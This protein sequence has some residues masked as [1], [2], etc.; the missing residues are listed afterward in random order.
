MS[1]RG[2]VSARREEAGATHRQRQSV[3]R[4]SHEHGHPAGRELQD[5]AQEPKAEALRHREE[6]LGDGVLQCCQQVCPRRPQDQG[7]PHSSPERS[8]H[9]PEVL[10]HTA[11]VTTMCY[12]QYAHVTLTSLHINNKAPQCSYWLEL[13]KIFYL[14]NNV[15]LNQGGLNFCLSIS[16]FSS[17]C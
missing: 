16:V 5:R 6:A 9:S 4:G 1:E 7:Q 3:I 2:K 12:R 13:D 15:S 11:K 10:L 8:P 17:Q 14:M